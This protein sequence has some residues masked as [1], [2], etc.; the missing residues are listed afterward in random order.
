[1]PSARAMARATR[2]PNWCARSPAPLRSQPRR[3]GHRWPSPPCRREYSRCRSTFA[4]ALTSR[5]R[6]E[7]SCVRCGY[8]CATNRSSTPYSRSC[9]SE[10]NPRA[11][12]CRHRAVRVRTGQAREG[13]LRHGLLLVRRGGVRE[14]AGR[15]QR[16]L[17]LH[18]RQGEEP[19]L[20]AGV[21]GAHRPYRVGRGD[22]RP[23]EG[24]LREAARDLLAEPRSDGEGPAVLRL[25]L[26][27]P[28]RDLLPFGGAEA[29]RRG[30][31]GEVG[32]REAFPPADPHADHAGERVLSGGGLPPG[33]LQEEP[34]AVPFLR[35]GLRPLP[36]AR[37]PVGRAAQQGGRE[38]AYF[39][40]LW[41]CPSW[42]TF[43]GSFSA[44]SSSFA[45]C[46]P[47][48]S[49]FCIACFSSSVFGSALRAASSTLPDSTNLRVR[50]L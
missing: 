30:L 29:A 17:G 33:L 25:G 2:E 32:E 13:H 11:R 35:L 16:R 42:G 23:G 31:Q 21:I 9:Q 28:A 48:R 22:L 7:Q 27:V 49:A 47:M 50:S 39:G 5:R 40:W 19:E 36:A 3:A 20:R 1:M 46:L 41:R 45:C 4:R 15:G 43:F 8:A 38:V 26:A 18:R 24:E 44:G 37:Q 34:A 6:E 10:K 12:S 14:G